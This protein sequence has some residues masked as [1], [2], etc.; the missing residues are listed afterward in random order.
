VDNCQLATLAGAE[1]FVSPDD[2]VSP[3]DFESPDDFVSPDDFDSPLDLADDESP[4]DSELVDVFSLSL[5]DFPLEPA[6]LSVR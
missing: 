6:R 2:F 4:E 3:E 5:V 1:D